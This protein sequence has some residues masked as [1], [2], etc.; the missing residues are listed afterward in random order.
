MTKNHEAKDLNRSNGETQPSWSLKRLVWRLR[1]TRN[2]N[3]SNKRHELYETMNWHHGWTKQRVSLYGLPTKPCI[4][5]PSLNLNTYAAWK[6]AVLIS[7]SS[8]APEKIPSWLQ[9]HPP[10]SWL[11]SHPPVSQ[12]PSKIIVLFIA[13]RLTINPIHSM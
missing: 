1:K 2:I 7:S 8:N 11:Q 3:I 10:A 9:S 12:L 6:P 13:C 5:E 4:E